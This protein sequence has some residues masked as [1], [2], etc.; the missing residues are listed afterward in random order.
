[1][2]KIPTNYYKMKA[3]SALDFIGRYCSNMDMSKNLTR[4]CFDIT[5]RG[6]LNQLLR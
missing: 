1:M 5:K 3:T 2:G 4:M 6:K